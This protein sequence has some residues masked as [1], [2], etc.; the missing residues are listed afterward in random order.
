MERRTKLGIAIV[1]MFTLL[2]GMVLGG[3]AGG[4]L[5]YYLAQ[6]QQPVQASSPALAKPIANIEQQ[7]PVAPAPAPNT[8]P[9][10]S[11]AGDESAVVGAVKQVSPAVVTVINTLKSDAQPSDMQRNPFPF[12]VPQPDQP[13]PNQ[14]QPNQPQPD[15]APVSYTHLTLPTIYSV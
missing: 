5:G 10:P 15:Q 8:A 13:Q 4:G 7:A 2:A 9:A 6:R 12:P 1:A 3:L 11:A 14:P